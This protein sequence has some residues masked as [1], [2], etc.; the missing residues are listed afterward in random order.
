VETRH[1]GSALFQGC[2]APRML[3]R[4]RLIESDADVRWGAGRQGGNGFPVPWREMLL[5]E[6]SRIEQVPPP[7]KVDREIGCA[8]RGARGSERHDP[9]VAK[10]PGFSG[11]LSTIDTV[12]HRDKEAM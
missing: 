5:G 2:F 6:R 12:G 1:D 4:A 11:Y 10:I 9:M 3:G 8:G 7:R